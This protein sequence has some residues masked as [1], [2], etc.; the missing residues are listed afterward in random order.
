MFSAAEKVKVC[1]KRLDSVVRYPLAPLEKD[2]SLMAYVCFGEIGRSIIST[3]FVV[4]LTSAMLTYFNSTF[5]RHTTHQV[6]Y[7]SHTSR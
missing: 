5:I 2:F 6:I 4:E 1:L 3:V 7:I